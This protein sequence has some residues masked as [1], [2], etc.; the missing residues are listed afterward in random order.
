MIGAEIVLGIIGLYEKH[1]WQTRRVLL[2]D[3]LSEKLENS[4]ETMFGEAEVV[5]SEINAVWFSRPSKNADVAWELRHLS[6]SPFA[7][8]EVF[9][10]DLSEDDRED[11]L[12]AAE[13]RLIEKFT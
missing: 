10:A 2:T 9:A 7:L 1:G 6:A 11:I 12:Q 3:E 5:F 8:I 4:L 13:M